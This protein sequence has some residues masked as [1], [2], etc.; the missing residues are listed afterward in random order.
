MSQLYYLNR[1]SVCVCVIVN[2]G[3][4]ICMH[5]ATACINCYKEDGVYNEV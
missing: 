2:R 4:E 5:F 1:P 3:I